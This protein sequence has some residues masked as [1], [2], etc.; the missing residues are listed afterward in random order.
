M[1]LTLIE[2][3]TAPITTGAGIL[4]AELGEVELAA[5]ALVWLPRRSRGAFTAGPAGCGI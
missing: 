3:T 4:S 1:E 5:G 2:A